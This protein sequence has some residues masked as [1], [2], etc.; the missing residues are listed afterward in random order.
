MEEGRLTPF[1]VFYTEHRD[2]I[3]RS[4]FKRP[5]EISK[6]VFRLWRMLGPERKRDYCLLSNLYAESLVKH[7]EGS[8]VGKKRKLATGHRTRRKKDPRLPKLPVSSFMWFS[9]HHRAILRN[10][11]QDL[12]F[13]DIGK[14]VGALWKTA[15]M[16]EKRP[17]EELAAEVCYNLHEILDLELS[18]ATHLSHVLAARHHVERIPCHSPVYEC[19]GIPGAFWGRYA[20]YRRLFCLIK[21]FRVGCTTLVDETNCVRG[22]Q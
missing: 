8:G 21:R 20:V 10:E 11:H 17:F 18:G 1:M 22:S 6:E 12:S 16:A 7:G 9:R 14:T 2:S 4:K 5:E 15:T 13:C 19:I 3:N